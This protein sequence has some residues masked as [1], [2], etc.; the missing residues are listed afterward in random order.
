[1]QIKC[2]I[3]DSMPILFKSKD[4]SFT[5]PA[6]N[7]ESHWRYLNRSGRPE[8]A[9]M[10][11]KIEGMLANYPEAHLDDIV[12]RLK[13]QNNDVYTS[14]M[15]ELILHEMLIK[16]GHLI[17]AIEPEIDTGDKRPDFLVQA[18]DGEKFYLEAL[19][20]SKFPQHE[21]SGNAIQ[22][23]FR[24]SANEIDCD[25]YLDVKVTGLPKQHPSQKMFKRALQGWANDLTDD[26][27]QA[28]SKP[29][30][31]EGNG[32]KV[33]AKVLF[34]KVNSEGRNIGLEFGTPG[35][36][37]PDGGLKPSL[38]VKMKKYGK[39]DL[40]LCIAISPHKMFVDFEECI[41]ALF[42]NPAVAFD[43]DDVEG[44]VHNVRDDTGL[45]RSKAGRYKRCSAVLFFKNLTE[46]SMAKQQG[47]LIHHPEAHHPLNG[48]AL[49]AQSYRLEGEY[50]KP[51]SDA[52]YLG[53][54]LGLPFEW[55]E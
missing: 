36:V 6:E 21:K 31:W 17:L 3:D 42:G 54:C 35:F 34:K 13:S 38:K 23:E 11:D 51:E 53:E 46:W 5:G 2:A 16:S 32:L 45:W 43:P 20:Y 39:L 22:D 10:R 8:A 40:P 47:K 18:P 27:K 14:V 9:K 41:N 15:F 33:I 7:G 55:P 1:M 44:S 4:R 50:I 19:S 29:F 24:N 26:E 12:R 48:S 37:P 49:P 52:V 28:K 30:I 25:Y